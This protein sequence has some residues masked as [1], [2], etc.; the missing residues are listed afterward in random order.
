[1]KLPDQERVFNPSRQTNFLLKQAEAVGPKTLQLCTELFE[2]RGREGQKSMWGVVNLA[3]NSR[4]PK[5]L[6][7]Q[8]CELA[9]A[10]GVRSSKSVRQMVESLL[11]EAIAR[12]DADAGA[13]EARSA[14][15][16]SHELIRPTAEYAEHFKQNV[17]SQSETSNQQGA[18]PL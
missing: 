2:N 14:L 6:I 4:Y 15:T 18:F 12:L 9:L 1:V 10:Q 16:Q 13:A 17:L 8:A 7:E 11:D 3:R 5:R